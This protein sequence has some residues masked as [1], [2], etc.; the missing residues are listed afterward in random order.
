MQNV[1]KYN[2]VKIEFKNPHNSLISTKDL[3]SDI[4]KQL[5]ISN[6]EF[7]TRSVV[8]LDFIDV[9]IEIVSETE[10]DDIL[11]IITPVLECTDMQT[12]ATITLTYKSGKFIEVPFPLGAEFKSLDKEILEK[13]VSLL[14][15]KIPP[16]YGFVLFAYKKNMSD[17]DLYTEKGEATQEDLLRLYKS[18]AASL[19]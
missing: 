19:K 11:K 1:R 10:C 14:S 18:Y 12:G 13:T 7:Y 16:K 5:N 8:S 9:S 15:E 17:F 6:I 2:K 4:R 3:E